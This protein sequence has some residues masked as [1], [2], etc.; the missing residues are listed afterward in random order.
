MAKIGLCAV[1]PFLCVLLLLDVDDNH[2]DKLTKR[3]KSGHNAWK[4]TKRFYRWMN[5]A[6]DWCC[7]F[8]DLFF[9]LSLFYV[10]R[11]QKCDNCKLR[12]SVS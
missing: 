7:N 10:N 11:A 6:F 8:V 3:L 5:I 1:F 4:R 12:M 2:E 9:C